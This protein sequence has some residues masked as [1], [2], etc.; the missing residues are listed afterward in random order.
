[1]DHVLTYQMRGQIA[2]LT[3]NRPDKA[4]AWNVELHSAFHDALDRAGADPQVRVVVLTGAGRHFCAGADLSILDHVQ[5]GGEPPIEMPP[6]SFMTPLSFA[7]PLIAAINGPTAGVGLVTALMCDIRFASPEAVFVSAFARLGLVAEYGVSWLLPQIVGRA[8]AM[9]LLLSGRKVG[10]DEALAI[11]LVNR[12]VSD[13]D[14]VDAAVAYAQ[15]LA[16]H[17]SPASM[18]VIKQQVH[19]H[20]VSS[21]AQADHEM[22]LVMEESLSGVDF[23]EGVSAFLNKRAT[24]F[25]SLGDGT[26][27]TDLN[28]LDDPR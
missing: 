3:L 6:D 26:L 20:A 13:G 21:L 18:A 4:N 1:M 15:D 9:D 12:I 2:L 24:A 7:K 28:G 8:H 22:Q 27:F 23:S 19:R 10:A 16:T 14:V 5:G 25:A 17:C 11:G